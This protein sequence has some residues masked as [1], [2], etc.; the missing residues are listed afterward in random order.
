MITCK[1]ATEMIERN[2]SNDLSMGELMKL[3]LH[4]FLC[5]ACKIY[6]NQSKQIDTFLKK[7]LTDSKASIDSKQ[8]KETIITKI[9]KE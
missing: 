9:E 4:L 5:K 7:Y 3:K 8:I 1:K 6:E 2:N